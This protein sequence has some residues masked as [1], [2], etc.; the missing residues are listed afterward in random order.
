MP[1]PCPR[2][3]PAH[4]VDQAECLRL[5][6]SFRSKE[7]RERKP[8]PAK[9]MT[10]GRLIEGSAHRRTTPPISSTQPSPFHDAFVFPCRRGLPSGSLCPPTPPVRLSAAPPS[11]TATRSKSEASAFDCTASMLRR[12]GKP[13]RMATA[14]PIGAAKRQPS[15]SISFS[16]SPARRAVNLSNAFDFSG[17]SASA[18]A[19]RHCLA[20]ATQSCSRP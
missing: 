20:R 1:F 5:V 6:L 2:S 7:I 14:A 17:L 9:L 18:L 11:S 16:P 4:R 12:V 8:F 10:M 3:R 15:R 19:K 13:A